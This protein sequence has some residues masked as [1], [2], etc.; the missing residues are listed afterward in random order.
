VHQVARTKELLT[1]T[2]EPVEVGFA[3]S[4]AGGTRSPSL[5]MASSIK[6]L[7]AYKKK[8]GTLSISKDQRSI[9]WLPVGARDADKSVSIPVASITSTWSSTR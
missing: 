1:L 4:D 7:A 2:R 5:R 8:D 9:V 3:G 6:G